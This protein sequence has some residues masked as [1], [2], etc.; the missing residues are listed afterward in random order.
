MQHSVIELDE[1]RLALYK[2]IRRPSLVDPGDGQLAPI[3]RK[4]G[5]WD[6]PVWTAPSPFRPTFL[7]VRLRKEN[8]PLALLVP[9]CCGHNHARSGLHAF[10]GNKLPF[11]RNTP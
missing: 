5:W 10:F 9:K 2:V 4:Y 6:E 11:A 3:H 8:A 1:S 7:C